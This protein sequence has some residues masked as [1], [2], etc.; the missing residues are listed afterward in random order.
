MRVY[1]VTRRARVQRPC[2]SSE[3]TAEAF[4]S[5]LLRMGPVYLARRW[6]RARSYACLDL[7]PPALSL[8]QVDL[9]GD[10]SLQHAHGDMS[11]SES[12]AHAHALT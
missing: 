9:G 2:N 3:Y 6:P 8:P 11:V 4:V 10:S 7:A 1:C 5:Y 12:G